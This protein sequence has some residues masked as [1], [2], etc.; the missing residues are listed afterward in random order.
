MGLCELFSVKLEG[1]CSSGVLRP[2]CYYILSTF[3]ST[4]I[5]EGRELW[6]YILEAGTFLVRDRRGMCLDKRKWGGT[7]DSRERE[8]CNQDSLYEK[9][10]IFNTME[11]F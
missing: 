11:M 3:S 1:L 2:F 6:C 9:Q 4:L 10:S 7:Q 5:S 8:P